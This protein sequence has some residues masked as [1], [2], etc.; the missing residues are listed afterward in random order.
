MLESL[1]DELEARTG[2]AWSAERTLG[3]DGSYIY[4]GE[5]GEAFVIDPQ[6]NIYRGNLGG[7][8]FTFGKGGVATPIYD[9]LKPL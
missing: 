2:G 5:Y 6:G 3:T 4:T 9:H 7:D 8:G 1:T